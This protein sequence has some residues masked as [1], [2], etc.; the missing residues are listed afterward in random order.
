MGCP[1]ALALA[2][3]HPQMVASLVLYW[4]V[5]GA[6][7]RINS[8]A[9]LAEHVA[10]VEQ[11]G[12]DGVVAL[13]TAEGKTFNQDPRGGIWASVIRR[14]PAFAQEY[15]R[16]DVAQYTA[17]VAGIRRNLFDRDT[18]PGADPEELLRLDLPALVVPGH[19]KSHATSAARF[20]EEC[21]PRAEYWDMPVEGQ[22]EQT[23]PPRLMEFVNRWPA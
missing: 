7:Y 19:D 14:E 18:A 3:A 8:H 17:V 12:L 20:L 13:V 22:T 1:P 4:P 2:V 9:R 21:L 11:Y 6:H 16:R 15:A 10:Y 5:G 23:V